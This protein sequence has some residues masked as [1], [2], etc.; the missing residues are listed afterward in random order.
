MVRKFKEIASLRLGSAPVCGGQC[1]ANVNNPLIAVTIPGKKSVAP[2]DSR[3]QSKTVPCTQMQRLFGFKLIRF[4]FCG[5]MGRII[6]SAF[7]RYKTAFVSLAFLYT[8]FNS[9]A[10]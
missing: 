8:W 2:I 9:E 10:V 6:K 4:S 5:Q 7:S 3:P 1:D